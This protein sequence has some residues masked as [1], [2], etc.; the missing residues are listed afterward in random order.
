MPETLSASQEVGPREQKNG[1]GTGSV[2]NGL[3]AVWDI[4]TPSCSKTCL[5]PDTQSYKVVTSPWT[6]TSSVYQDDSSIETIRSISY[7][8][9]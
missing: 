8:I 1:I 2:Q 3:L 7:F 6:I 4:E 5:V 9:I